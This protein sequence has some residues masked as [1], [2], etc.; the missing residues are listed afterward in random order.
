MSAIT[1]NADPALPQT[2]EVDTDI[3]KDQ[4]KFLL[5]SSVGATSRRDAVGYAAITH[6]PFGVLNQSGVRLKM[7]GYE[8]AYRFRQHSDNFP[9]TVT[10]LHGH[11]TEI[12]AFVGYECVTETLNVAGF[13]GL[14]HQS[15]TP[16]NDSPVNAKLH[17]QT[18]ADF[19][20]EIDYHPAGSVSFGFDGSYSTVGS[21]VVTQANVGIEAASNIVVGPE[22]TYQSSKS[23]HERRFGARIGPL[24]IGALTITV[25][26]GFAHAK[27]NGKGAYGAIESS[28]RF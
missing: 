2:E 14:D 5:E 27:S 22:F 11:N 18:G 24:E 7:E 8:F 20:T 25:T 21:F 26:S 1:A 19:S 12:E 16:S 6:A 17:V 9:H 13:L 4:S 3:S 23:F 10:F 15:S 28:F